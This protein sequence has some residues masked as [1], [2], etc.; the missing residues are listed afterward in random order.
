MSNLVGMRDAKL[1]HQILLVT[2][3]SVISSISTFM[4]VSFHDMQGFMTQR[5]LSMATQNW[6]DDL[7]TQNVYLY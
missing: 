5:C 3:Y 1:G 2:E 7:G 6:K 4:K